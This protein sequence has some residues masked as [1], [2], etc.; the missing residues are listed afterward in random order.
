M[1]QL[2]TGGPFHI[3]R[4]ADGEIVGAGRG[5]MWSPQP[6]QSIQSFTTFGER[7]TNPD[8]IAWRLSL[9]HAK[10]AH[11]I[12]D[13]KSVLAYAAKRQDAI[14]VARRGEAYDPSI[15]EALAIEV[16][17]CDCDP[18]EAAEKILVAVKRDVLSVEDERVAIR[19]AN[20][21]E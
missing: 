5:P 10:Q 12:E 14:A 15:H 18:I 11:K 19:E 3:R 7:E 1:K 17:R 20:S 6:G 9:Y 13:L 16:E 4:N 8:V 21:E 2:P